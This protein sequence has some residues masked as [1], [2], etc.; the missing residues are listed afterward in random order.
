MTAP[1][2]VLEALRAATAEGHRALE[3]TPTM[4]ALGAPD[5]DEAALARALQV[6]AAGFGEHE[7]ALAGEAWYRPQAPAIR[8]DLERLGLAPSAPAAV[9]EDGSAASLVGIAYVL[10]GSRLGA[11]VTAQRLAQRFGEDFVRGLQYFGA[12]ASFSAP[13]WRAF[14]E[15]AGLL[16]GE[17]ARALACAAAVRT[18]RRFEQLARGGAGEGDEA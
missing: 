16:E 18:F 13:Q 17:E 9:A 5:C 10:V 2:P 14:Q 3:S 11:R 4:A 7:P 6:L 15:R 12:E 8:R 1:S